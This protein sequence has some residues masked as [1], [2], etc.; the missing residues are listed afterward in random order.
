MNINSNLNI[1][2]LFSSLPNKNTSDADASFN[3]LSSL[4]SDYNMIK[5]GSYGKLM[6]AYYDKNPDVSFENP[7]TSNVK[8]ID[9]KALDTVQSN[10]SELLKSTES[11]LTK[12]DNSYF[13]D[14][15]ITDVEALTDA[16][17]N[18]VDQYNDLLKEATTSTT[19]SVSG[20]ANNLSIM[21]ELKEKS[22][23]KIGI[24]VDSNNLLS[25]DSEVFKNASSEDIESIFNASGSYMSN[26][27]LKATMIDQYANM[28][29]Y[30]SVSYTSDGSSATSY[31]GG[32]IIDTIF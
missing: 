14:G 22:L 12:T 19:T 7:A 6:T 1:N 9:K 5:T 25:F 28:A 15:E 13:K 23:N 26:V 10:A 20:E 31:T 4:L 18:F 27:A 8:Y 16:A 21:T 30:D 11:F 24:T 32:N 17:S 29:T 2:T 3:S